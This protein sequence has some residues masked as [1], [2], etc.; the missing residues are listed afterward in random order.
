[1][2]GQAIKQKLCGEKK[3]FKGLIMTQGKINVTVAL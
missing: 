1:M 2:H 3:L